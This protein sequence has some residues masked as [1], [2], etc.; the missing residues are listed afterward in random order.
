[1]LPRATSD[2]M[3]RRYLLT[4]VTSGTVLGLA[5]CNS[6]SLG[7]SKR[8]LNARRTELQE[9]N[10]AVV[11]MVTPDNAFTPATVTIHVGDSVGWLNNSEWGHT[12]TAYEDGIPEEA[13]FF[14]TGGY[15][16]EQA[17]R[18]AWPDG[19]IEV[20]ESYEHTFE[21]AG[22][23]EYFCVPHEEEMVGT[24]IVESE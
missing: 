18:N 6:S 16:T 13:A 23:Y 4:A 14:S 11:G 12:V 24:V 1:M 8:Q 2:I 19:D 7:P 15:D 21:V 3:R 17:A 22:E 5:G 20:G 10:D 9:R